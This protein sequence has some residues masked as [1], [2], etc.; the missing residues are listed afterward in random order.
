MHGFFFLFKPVIF[1]YA[2]GTNRK[3]QRL[4]LPLG[5]Q[6][7][8]FGGFALT[9]IQYGESLVCFGTILQRC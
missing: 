2:A 5:L 3:H 6:F 7:D 4:R 9:L 8:G 1:F